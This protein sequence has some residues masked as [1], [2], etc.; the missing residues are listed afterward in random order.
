M[1]HAHSFS[2]HYV[3]AVAIAVTALVTALVTVPAGKAHAQPDPSNFRL[4]RAD[5]DPDLLDGLRDEL[6]TVSVSQVLDSANRTARACYPQVRHRTAS[7]CWNS[8]DSSVDYWMPQGITTTGDATASGEWEGREALLSSWYD[9]ESGRDMGVRISFVDMSDRSTPDYRH[10]LLV[11]PE[12]QNGEPSFRRVNAHAG[13]ISWYGDQLYVN[14]TFNGL[15]VFNMTDLMRVSTGDG[16][17]IGR[18]PDGSYHAH[19]YL[20]VLPQEAHY[21]PSTT[22][23]ADRFRYSQ[24]SL[25]RTT[26]PHSLVTSEY[27]YPGTDTRIVRF[28]LNEDTHHIAEDSDG[29][30]RGDWAYEV[31]IRSMQG[32]VSVNGKFHIHRSNG[33]STRGD[34][35]TWRPGNWATE[36]TGAVPIGPEDVTYWS[37]H[38]EIWSQTE[39]PDKRY[40]YASR[41]SSW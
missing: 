38:G 22:G 31:G 40:V 26:S 34:V 23:G 10:V 12:W 11:E 3:I 24:T 17:A 25:D 4:E 27:G 37:H 8:G 15:R 18:Q 41:E 13:G 35:F 33:S 36:Y 28:N 1:A 6:G 16:S 9:K 29:Y 14:N 21:V 19:N 30:A 32:A 39:Y 20:Y 5:T 7:F 2:R